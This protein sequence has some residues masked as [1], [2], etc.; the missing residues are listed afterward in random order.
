MKS[1]R[2]VDIENKT[3]FLRLD[4]NVPLKGEEIL[5]DNRIRAT[6]PTINYLLSKNCRIIIGTHLGRP[7]GDFVP[8]LTTKI[9]A[10]RLSELC[11]AKVY[12]T[13]Q[14]IE[15]SVKKMVADLH[16]GEILVLGNLRFHSEEEV[17]SQAFARILASYADIFVNDAFAVCHRAHASVEAITNYLSGYAGLLLEKEVNT[18]RVLTQRPRRPFIL[19]LGGAKIKDKSKLIIKFAPLVDKILVGGAI[20]N[21]LRYFQGNE[22]SSSFY[23]PRLEALSE[24]ILAAIGDK[25][26]LP[27][28]DKRQELANGQYSIMDIGPKTI[29]RFKAKISGAKTIFWNGNMGCSEKKE[30]ETGTLEIAEAIKDNS[31]TKIVAGGDTVG[32]IDS[33]N[34][35]KGFS[36]VSTGGG[37]ALEFLAGIELPAL[38]ALG[39]YS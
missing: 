18:L 5:N 21:T 27:V 20:A 29:N 23:E 8:Q 26:I 37:A 38:K 25:I 35:A 39:Y 10:K 15:P 16:P 14:V 6:L 13:D 12:A 31:F 32:F 7:D 3:V 24:Q 33:K 2:E 34:L 28:D 36:F 30:F 11:P 9:L 17:N 1:V 19:V 22:I 4:W